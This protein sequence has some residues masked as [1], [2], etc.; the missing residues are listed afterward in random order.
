VHWK[1]LDHGEFAAL[2]EEQIESLAARFSLR[3]D[4]LRKLS[5]AVAI[6]LSPV[7]GIGTGLIPASRSTA[8]ARGTKGLD[9]ALK[10]VALAERHLRRAVAELNRLPP[11]RAADTDHV[12]EFL[13]TM[14]SVSSF[15]DQLNAL[16][17]RMAKIAKNPDVALSIAP[18]NW[19]PTR[20]PRR[21][22]VLEDIFQFWKSTGHDTFTTETF[23]S[24]RRGPLI[25]FVNAVF[26]CISDPPT[27]LGAELIIAEFRKFSRT[28][29]TAASASVLK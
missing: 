17:L 7:P 16:G 2:S 1:P 4:D 25:E 12:N 28:G 19:R 29:T 23:N 20:D 5:R 11:N 8:V 3:T 14:R 26:A 18:D 9:R 22:L 27:K 21:K 6:D 13:E 10:Q 15:P 24:R